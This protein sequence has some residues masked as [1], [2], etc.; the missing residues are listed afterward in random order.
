[1]Q[2]LDVGEAL[3]RRA[4][5]IAQVKPERRQASHD[6]VEDDPLLAQVLVAVEKPVAEGCVLAGGRAAVGRAGER[7]GEDDT[8]IDAKETLRARADEAL[9]VSVGHRERI[10]VRESLAK[11]VEEPQGVQRSRR[12]HVLGPR[13]DDLLKFPIRDVLEG[14]ADGGLVAP[15]PPDLVDGRGR[16]RKGRELGGLEVE[17]AELGMGVEHLCGERIDGRVA[18]DP[19]GLPRPSNPTAVLVGHLPAGHEDAG[20]L[21]RLARA[22][23]V[24]ERER[25]EEMRAAKGH[26]L[27]PDRDRVLERPVDEPLAGKEAAGTRRRE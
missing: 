10:A 12:P 1:M 16:R 15:S 20:G 13:E 7:L 22:H 9:T 25:C 23:R 26:V 14:P 18:L 19:R 8:V 27:V 5:G 24:Q 2:V 17:G 3:E 4:G 21:E 11:A 6:R